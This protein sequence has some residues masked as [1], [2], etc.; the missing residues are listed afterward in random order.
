MRQA[1]PV[2]SVLRLEVVGGVEGAVQIDR[3]M[4]DAMQADAFAGGGGIG[5]HDPDVFV[6]VEGLDLAFASVGIVLV[7]SVDAAMNVDGT[8]VGESRGHVFDI[9][10]ERGPDQDFMTLAGELPRPL[11]NVFQL[12]AFAFGQD[13]G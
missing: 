2:D 11:E 12:G 9:P 4:A 1:K 5:D 13:R 7:T 3:V 10:D 8:E 6:V